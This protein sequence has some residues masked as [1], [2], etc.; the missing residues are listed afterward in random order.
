MLVITSVKGV[1][2]VKLVHVLGT[3]ILWDCIAHWLSA[4]LAVEAL[5]ERIRSSSLG[6]RVKCKERLTVVQINE[7]DMKRMSLF[8]F[9]S[10]C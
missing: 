1:K 7:K 4:L 2:R 6:V 10:F 9:I 3:C 5:A 8:H